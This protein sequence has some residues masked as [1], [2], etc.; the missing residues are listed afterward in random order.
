MPRQDLK[1][2]LS[3]LQASRSKLKRPRKATELSPPDPE[4]VIVIDPDSGSESDDLKT[5][6]A[7]IKAQ[8]ESERIARRM[9]Y[10]LDQSLTSGSKD[11]ESRLEDDEAMAR[12]LAEEWAHEDSTNLENTVDESSMGLEEVASPDA[13]ASSSS[14]PKRTRPLTETRTTMDSSKSQ[15]RGYVSASIRPDKSLASFRH[16]FTKTRPCS[17]CGKDLQSPRGCVS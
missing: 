17:K 3:P 6:L 13:S 10:D 7:Q 11:T 8:E 4:D 16:I 15:G 1:R 14:L 12:R 9:Q 5:I 2:N